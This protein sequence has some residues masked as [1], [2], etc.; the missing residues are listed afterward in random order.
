MALSDDEQDMI[1][2]QHI[3]L[4]SYPGGK[5]EV[6]KSSLRDFGSPATNTA[7]ARTVALPASIIV[8]MILE[9]SLSLTGVLRPV[10][11]DIYIPVL[12]ELKSLG[13]EIEEEYGLPESA[14][15]F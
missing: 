10:H 12:D 9:K 2:M 11:P 14:M 8:K 5:S 6:I 3:F 13:I 4:A 15:N 1:V 7:I